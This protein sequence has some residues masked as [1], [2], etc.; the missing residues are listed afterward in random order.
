MISS[1]FLNTQYDGAAGSNTSSRHR[2]RKLTS[3]SFEKDERTVLAKKKRKK[4]DN[5]FDD[6]LIM[7]NDFSIDLDLPEVSVPHSD[8]NDIF[9]WMEDIL[10]NESDELSL[11]EDNDKNS[12]ES[13]DVDSFLSLNESDSCY[14]EMISLLAEGDEDGSNGEENVFKKIQESFIA[15]QLLGDHSKSFTLKRS[16]SFGTRLGRTSRIGI[17]QGLTKLAKANSRSAKTRRM[18]LNCRLSFSTKISQ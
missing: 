5:Y 16:P 15:D 1:M 10:G 3:P 7:D 11:T 13:I 17:R 2:K 8:D 4:V 14:E 18:L 9:E 6:I 12:C